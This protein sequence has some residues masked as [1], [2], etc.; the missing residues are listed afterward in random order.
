MFDWLGNALGGV[1]EGVTGFVGDIFKGIAEGV[2]MF[3]TQIVDSLGG[4]TDLLDGF[5][6]GMGGMASGFW[7][8]FGSLFPFI[9]PE[10]TAIISTGLL[11]TVVGIII[12]K[13]V[14]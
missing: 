14:F 11:L 10:W 4:L 1:V 5:I 12:K 9:P 2:I 8:L 6:S 13:K 7:S 3:L